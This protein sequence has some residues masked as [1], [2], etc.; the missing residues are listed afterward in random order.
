MLNQK[1]M[2]KEKQP[3]GSDVWMHPCLSGYLVS[4]AHP[5][6]KMPGITWST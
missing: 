3:R 6:R 5:F 4:Q 1:Q 2:L